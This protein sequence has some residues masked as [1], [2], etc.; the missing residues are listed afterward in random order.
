MY[1]FF[2][3]HFNTCYCKMTCTYVCITF[4]DFMIS[5]SILFEPEGHIVGQEQAINCTATLISTTEHSVIFNWVTPDGINIDDERITILPTTINENNYTSV[6][7]F[8]YLME[9]DNGTYICEIMSNNSTTSASTEL[10]DLYG[11]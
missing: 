2:T 6:L 10:Q 8:E 1:M 5:S 11:K 4:T 9:S 3:M 7:Q